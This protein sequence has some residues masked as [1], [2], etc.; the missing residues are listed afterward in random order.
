MHDAASRDTRP[1]PTPKPE[2]R[3]PYPGAGVPKPNRSQS[4]DGRS[5]ECFQCRSKIRHGDR[6]GVCARWWGHR[7][8][9]SVSV[10][11]L[12]HI[13]STLAALADTL[14]AIADGLRRLANAVGE[15]AERMKQE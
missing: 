2:P 3:R 13:A 9:D 4:D 5:E 6:C 7:S 14:H 15:I 10:D 12:N 1:H 8:C 11:P